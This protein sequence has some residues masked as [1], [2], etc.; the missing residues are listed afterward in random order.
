GTLVR[1]GCEPQAVLASRMARRVRWTGAALLL[2]CV[3]LVLAGA[4][5]G[6]LRGDRTFQEWDPVVRQ[7]LTPL[8]V[9]GAALGL[10]LVL[11]C[12]GVWTAVRAGAQPQRRRARGVVELKPVRKK[13]TVGA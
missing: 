12:A 7:W 11:M 4:V 13:A 1:Y 3:N 5:E 2:V 10:A 9:L 8:P 6:V